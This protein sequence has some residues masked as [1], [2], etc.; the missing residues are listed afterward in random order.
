MVQANL[1]ELFCSLITNLDLKYHRQW[2]IIILIIAPSK[3]NLKAIRLLAANWLYSFKGA[4]L[5]FSST[6]TEHNMLA[7]AIAQNNASVSEHEM[8]YCRTSF[9][10]RAQHEQVCTCLLYA[11]Y[12]Y[13]CKQCLK[14]ISPKLLLLIASILTWVL[15]VSQKHTHPAFLPFSPMYSVAHLLI[16]ILVNSDRLF[17]IVCS[18]RRD[19]FFSS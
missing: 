5:Q 1:L 14:F 8:I 3:S 17:N 2:H 6:P 11:I 15:F 13:F 10:K 16:I 4:M 12:S 19:R 18:S 9:F 7:S